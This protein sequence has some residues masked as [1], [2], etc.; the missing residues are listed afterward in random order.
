MC[1]VELHY[2][3]VGRQQQKLD[4]I[5]VVIIAKLTHLGLFNTFY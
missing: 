2:S 5:E 3:H 1:T 4:Y